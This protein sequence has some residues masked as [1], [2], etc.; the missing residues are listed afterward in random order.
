[1]TQTVFNRIEKKYVL[2]QAQYKL[3]LEKIM[4]YMVA[5]SYGVTT[6]CNL[7]FDTIHF[8]LISRSIE[9][10]IYKE[11]VR[12]RSYGIP[13]MNS[14][15]FL[16]VKKKYKKLVNKRRITLPLKEALS[17]QKRTPSTQIEREISYTF[18]LY[19]LKPMMFIAY[20]R[21]AFFLKNDP[22][23]R[24]TFDQNI[25]YRTEDLKLELGDAGKRILPKN[26]YVMEV[27][28]TFSYPLWFTDILLELHIYPTSFS[29]YG[30][31][32]QNMIKE[33]KNYV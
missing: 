25:R 26:T 19:Q 10:P 13:D 27:K 5:D 20:E 8:D 3:I 31:A 14:T 7:Y 11:K 15:V 32:Y 29:K 33:G 22:D 1:M 4:P 16:E 12:L 2:N 23:F 6:I 28:T 30:T 17:F 24:I 21:S 9:K 18:L